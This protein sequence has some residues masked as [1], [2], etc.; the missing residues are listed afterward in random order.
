MAKIDEQVLL[1]D[2]FDVHQ[3]WDTPI[4]GFFIIAS[5]DESKK[6][7]AD[8]TDKEMTELGLVLKKVRAAMKEKLKINTVYLFQ[9][10]DTEYGFHIWLFPRHEW[11][12]RFGTN[13]QSIRK[14]MEYAQENMATGSVLKEVKEAAWKVRDSLAIS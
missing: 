14:I 7:V 9:S 11:M 3:D 13:I 4:P 5:R 12:N 2:T 1:T 8:F 6:S 10:E